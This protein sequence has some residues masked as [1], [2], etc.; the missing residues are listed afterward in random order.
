MEIGDRKG[1]RTMG[2][3]W[4]FLVCSGGPSSGDSG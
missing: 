1:A 4:R 3:N 2:S